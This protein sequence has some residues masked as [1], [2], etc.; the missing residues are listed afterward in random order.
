LAIV[1]SAAL[2]TLLLCFFLTQQ[3]SINQQLAA[4]GAGTVQNLSTTTLTVQIIFT[5]LVSLLF[6]VTNAA[7]AAQSFSALLIR[8]TSAAELMEQGKLSE[9]EAK[10][11]TEVESN[12]E[13]GQLAK[14][15]GRMAEEVLQREARLKQQI[16]E[17]RIEIDE[18]RKAREVEDIT[19]TD[20]FQDLQRRAG[21]LRRAAARRETEPSTNPAAD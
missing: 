14:V 10:Q 9:S 6:A 13:I 2:P 16:V 1:I 21:E 8:L 4:S 12:D 20:Y 15:F 17:L 18:A 3:F 7:L 19:G 5:V 11:L